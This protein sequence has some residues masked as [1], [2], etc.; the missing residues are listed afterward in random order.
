MVAGTYVY[1]L[2]FGM[3]VNDV[4]GK[5]IANLATD[6]LSHPNRSSTAT[7]SSSSRRSS[8]C[9]VASRSRPGS[10]QVHTRA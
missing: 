7:R 6:E 2:I 9:A 4:S 10:G 3:T 8:R 1:S 5:A